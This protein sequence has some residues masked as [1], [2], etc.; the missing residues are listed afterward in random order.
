MK[1]CLKI[2][3]IL[4]IVSVMISSCQ[5]TSRER[6]KNY[7]VE[8]P[9]VLKHSRYVASSIE[10]ERIDCLNDQ[11]F[12][13]CFCIV[14]LLLNTTLHLSNVCLPLMYS[15]ISA[16]NCCPLLSPTTSRVRRRWKQ[17]EESKPDCVNLVLQPN[18]WGR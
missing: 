17:P 12:S 14:Q 7:R 4:L 15:A 18:D 6:T 10:Q 2:I 5:T 13:N 8:K 16:P 3:F 1:N 9:G 11:Y